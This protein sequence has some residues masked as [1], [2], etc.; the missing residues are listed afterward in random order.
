MRK[1]RSDRNH[2]IYRIRCVTTEDRYIGITVAKKRAFKKSAKERLNK[3]IYRAMIEQASLP[4]S[5]LI[6][7][8]GPESFLIEIL[9]I[10]RGKSAAHRREK[11]LI[12]RRNPSLNVLC[13][14]S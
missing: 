2:I 13:K 8:E 1:K 14:E 6:R 12:Q 4:L 10:V 5:D 3:H 11:E 9:E 7:Q